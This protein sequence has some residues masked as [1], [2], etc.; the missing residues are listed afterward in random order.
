MLQQM[1][2]NDLVTKL[3]EMLATAT[4]RRDTTAIVLLFG[5]LFNEEIRDSGSSG[6]R[7]AEAAAGKRYGPMIKNG[8]ALARFKFVE[9]TPDMVRKW[10]GRPD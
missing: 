1:S 5:V 6:Q 7:L 4:P 3:E 8:Q 10:K 9:P 2:H